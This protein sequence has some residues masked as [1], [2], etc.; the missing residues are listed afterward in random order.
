LNLFEI[1]LLR[2]E[3]TLRTNLH[4]IHKGWYLHADSKPHFGTLEKLSDFIAAMNIPY[5]A[6]NLRPWLGGNFWDG[7]VPDLAKQGLQPP[8]NP[9]QMANTPKGLYTPPNGG[10]SPLL[11]QKLAKRPYTPLFKQV[12][13]QDAFQKYTPKIPLGMSSRTS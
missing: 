11:V 10:Y 5:R 7:R 12:Y 9:N 1:L 13:G 4:A 3:E 2:R 8:N 6:A